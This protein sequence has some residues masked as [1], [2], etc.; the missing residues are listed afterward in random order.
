MLLIQNAT[1]DW[2]K[3]WLFFTPTIQEN[4]KVVCKKTMSETHAFI[5]SLCLWNV[6]ITA[7]VCCANSIAVSFVGVL[8]NRVFFKKQLCWFL[9]CS[10]GKKNQDFVQPL[11]AF[12]ISR[13]SNYIRHSYILVHWLVKSASCD[14]KKNPNYSAKITSSCKES[15]SRRK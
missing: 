8:H 10:E 1:N 2:T 3:S 11:V 7:S 6:C 13:I 4:S 15:F 5:T 9:Q 12:P 14:Q